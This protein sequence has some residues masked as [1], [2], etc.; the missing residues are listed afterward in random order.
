VEKAG[1]RFQILDDSDLIAIRKFGVLHPDGRP[2][3]GDIALPAQ[4]LFDKD[5]RLVWQFVS[6][7]AA[8][9]LPAAEVMQRVRAL[10]PN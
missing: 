9:R 5:G 4:F 7:R 3:G 2:T 8:D 1:L 10:S 6:R